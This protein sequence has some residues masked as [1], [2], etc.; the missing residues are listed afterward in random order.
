MNLKNYSSFIFK[1][2]RSSLFQKMTKKGCSHIYH[3][4]GQSQGMAEVTSYIYM[5]GP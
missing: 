2:G 1:T 5:P 3:Y 4:V